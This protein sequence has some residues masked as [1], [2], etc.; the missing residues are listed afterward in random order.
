MGVKVHRKLRH[1]AVVGSAWVPRLSSVTRHQRS[2]HNNVRHSALSTWSGSGNGIYIWHGVTSSDVCN[3][4]A[5][6]QSQL[7]ASRLLPTP[8][9]LTQLPPAREVLLSELNCISIL[10]YARHVCEQ[11]GPHS[12]SLRATL[13][14]WH[15][16]ARRI[17]SSS[18]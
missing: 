18:I 14:A 17:H 8:Q 3:I 5:S 1:V 16:W 7:N 13:L 4:V 15:P 11:E 6:L 2:P 10:D 12:A 9:Q